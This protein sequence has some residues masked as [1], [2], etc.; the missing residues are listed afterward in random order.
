M[1]WSDVSV[2]ASVPVLA[3][4]GQCTHGS[5]LS[6]SYYCALHQ[7]DERIVPVARPK[8]SD[9]NDNILPYTPDHIFGRGGESD[10]TC[11]HQRGLHH[12]RCK[13]RQLLVCSRAPRVPKTRTDARLRHHLEAPR[14]RAL[15]SNASATGRLKQGEGVAW[16]TTPS[17]PLSCVETVGSRQGQGPTPPWTRN[18][19]LL[20]RQLLLPALLLAFEQRDDRGHGSSSLP[21][22]R[23]RRLQG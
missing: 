21:A 17:Q 18:C 22:K 1:S 10:A 12:P 4:A 19:R 11:W 8:I 13:P 15:C 3:M 5:P 2:R 16:V 9:H 14:R 7:L 6:T 20:R 23:V